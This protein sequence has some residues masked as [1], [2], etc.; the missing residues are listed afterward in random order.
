MQESEY[1]KNVD[2]NVGLTSSEVEERI[3]NKQVNTTLTKTSKSYAKIFLSNIFTWLNI[4]CFI[5]AGVLI[6]IGSYNNIISNYSYKSLFINNFKYRC[7]IKIKRCY[8]NG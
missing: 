1:N 8:Q 3:K 2:I 7:K 5:V 4:I 6:A